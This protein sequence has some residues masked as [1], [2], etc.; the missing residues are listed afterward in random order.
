MKRKGGSCLGAFICLGVLFLMNS[1]T[2]KAALENNPY[3]SFS[4]DGSAYTTNAGDTA[5]EWYKTGTLADTGVKSSV[6]ELEQGQH[7][8]EKWIT[9]EVA[10]GTWEVMHER[11]I[12]SHD[13]HFAGADFHGISYGKNK[14]GGYYYSG[15]FP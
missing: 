14:C 3:I 4:P 12:C 15:W 10:V 1:I 5:Y 9:G 7:Y 2:V 11:G 13:D 8:Y 6:G